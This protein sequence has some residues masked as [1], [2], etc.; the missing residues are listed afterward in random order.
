M[1]AEI[2]P[3]EIKPAAELFA[4]LDPVSAQYAVQFVERLLGAACRIGASDIHLQPLATGLEVRWRIDGVLDE[5]GVFPAGVEA[6]VIARLKI[7]AG[8]LT[9][10]VDMPQEGRIAGRQPA[11][12][13]ARQHVSHAVRRTGRR[14]AVCQRGAVS[15]IA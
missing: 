14:A 5:L 6:N 4:G 12:R 9:Y 3:A 15:T 13:N 7:L 1:P 8:L 10:R 2:R 11:S